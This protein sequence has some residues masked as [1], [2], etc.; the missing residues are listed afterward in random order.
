MAIVKLD[1]VVRKIDVNED[2]LQT[3]LTYYVAGE[4]IDSQ[5]FMVRKRGVIKGSTIGYQ[6]HYGFKAGDILY[7]T[8]NPHLRKA[9][10]VDFDGICSIATFVLRTKDE[11]ELLQRYLLIELQSD[12]FWDFCEENKSGSVNYFINWTT[13]SQYEFDLPS[14]DVQ[15]EIADKAWAA[16]ELKESYEG[17][18]KATDELVKSRFI[19]MVAESGCIEKKIQEISSIERKNVNPVAGTTYTLYSFPAYDNDRTPEVIDGSEIKSSKLLLTPNTVLY[20]KLNVRLRRVWNVRSIETSNNICSTEFIPLHPKEDEILQEYLMYYLT[21]DS[22][23]EA[24]ENASRGT[25]NS[26]QRIPPK[27]ILDMTIPVLPIE[28][29]KRFISVFQQADK[30]KFELRQ[31]IDKVDNII[32]AIINN[33]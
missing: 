13:L 18:I 11:K 2:R 15:K 16:Y 8:K 9:S 27:A 25:S 33:E 19:E 32:R 31:A 21:S 5:S 7:M 22:V 6:F 26:Q 14:I 4:H 3:S 17:L 28:T 30:S 12:R 20:N 24:M 29:Q 10:M 1:D 23:T